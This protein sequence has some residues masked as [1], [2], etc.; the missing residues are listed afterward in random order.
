MTVIELP[1][2]STWTPA[3]SAAEYLGI[4]PEGLASRRRR[5]GR[6]HPRHV[7]AGTAVFY[8]VGDLKRYA[9]GWRDGRRK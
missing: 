2:G 6:R 7:C 1:P 9:Q 5:E 8:D 3:P 4:S